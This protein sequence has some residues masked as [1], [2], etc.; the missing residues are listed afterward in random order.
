MTDIVGRG[1]GQRV[2]HVCNGCGQNKEGGE[3]SASQR[4]RKAT[5]RQCRACVEAK[6][7]GKAPAAGAGRTAATEMGGGTPEIGKKTL[8]QIKSSLCGKVRR[9]ARLAG[10][11]RA[12][13]TY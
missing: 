9:M 12:V 2:A 5:V 6:E 3:F 10:A 8:Q 11:C 7:S 4:K 1:G 13:R